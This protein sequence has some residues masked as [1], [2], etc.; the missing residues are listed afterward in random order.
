MAIG[1][2]GVWWSSQFVT[3]LLFGVAPT[4]A[5]TLSAAILVLAILGGLAAL[6]PARR[7]AS[8]DPIR[9]LREQ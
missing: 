2:V 3:K 9:V 5:W 4:D 1:I 7:A 8:L 6:V